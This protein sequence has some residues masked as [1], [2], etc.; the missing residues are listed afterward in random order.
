MAERK[1]TGRKKGSYSFVMVLMS[2]LR[3][4]VSDTDVIVISNKWAKSIGI[5]G[6]PVK[7]VAGSSMMVPVATMNKP[8][9]PLPRRR[10]GESKKLDTVVVKTDNEEPDTLQID[11]QDW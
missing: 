2:E 5:E 8:Q 4:Q 11:V 9:L 1:S 7:T 6:Q 10:Q 3:K